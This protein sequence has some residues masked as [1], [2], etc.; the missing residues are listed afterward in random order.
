MRNELNSTLIAS[1]ILKP[2]KSKNFKYACKIYLFILSF[3]PKISTICSYDK[4]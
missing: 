3:P 2:E 1:I 4:F